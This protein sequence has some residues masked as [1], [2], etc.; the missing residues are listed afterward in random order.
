MRA[1]AKDQTEKLMPYVL[2]S[3]FLLVAPAVFAA[4][5]Y[6]VLGRVIRN[7]HAETPSI[8]HVR[9]LTKIFVCDDIISFVVQA[10][11]A[12]RVRL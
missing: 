1:T 5:V 4:S 7:L 9:W 3:T 12:G 10:G 2:Q 11:G 8:V 6:M